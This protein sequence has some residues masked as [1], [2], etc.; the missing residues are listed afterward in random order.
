MLVSFPFLRNADP[1]ETDTIDDG[2]FN[3]GEK[4]GKGAFPVS[5]Q[6]GWHGGVHLVAPGA[7]NDPEPVRAIADGE[8]VFA[9]HSDPMPLNSGSAEVQAAHPLLYYTGWT[10]NGVMLIKHQTEIG[11]GVGVTFYSIYQHLHT[12]ANKPGTET[13]LKKGDKVYRKDPI[14][15]AGAV[16]GKPNRIHFEIVADQRNVEALMGRSAGPLTAPQ[17][18]RTSVWGDMHIVL[19]ANTV[20][21]THDPR[22]ESKAYVVRTSHLGSGGI[23]DSLNSVAQRFHTTPERIRRLNGTAAQ[24]AN[25]WSTVAA[26][27]TVAQRT[28]RVPAQYGAAA[29]A[30]PADLSLE[31]WRHWHATRS[32]RTPADLIISLSEVRGTILLTTRDREGAVIGRCTEPEGGYNLYKT[33]LKHYPG[34]PSAGYEM[35]RFGRILGPDAPGATDMQGGRLPHVRKI[36]TPGGVQAFVDLNPAGVKVYSDADFPDW[37][38]WTFIDDDTDGN[39]RCDSKQLL[40]L[41]EPMAPTPNPAPSLPGVLGEA[42]HT[43]AKVLDTALHYKDR[44]ARAYAKIHNASMRK[45]LSYCVAKLPT[46]WSRDDFDQRW[47]WIKGDDPNDLPANVLLSLCLS[48]EAYDKLKRHHGALAF[49]ED[50]VKGGLALGKVH[51]HFHPLR[52]IEVF[53]RCGWLSPAELRQMVPARALRGAGAGIPAQIVYERVHLDAGRLVLA[54][55]ADLNRVLSKYGINTPARLAAFFGNAV[56][57]TAW[58]RLTEEVQATNRWYAPWIGRGFLQLTHPSNYLDYWYWRGRAIDADVE[59]RLRLAQQ[60]ANAQR[61]NQPLQEMETQLPRKMVDWR[62]NIADTPYDATD[63]A[64]YYWAMNTANREADVASRNV[65]HPFTIHTS[66]QQWPGQRFTFYEHVS[67]RRVSCLINLPGH[68]NRINPQLNGLV[69]RYH[70]HAYAQVLLLDQSIFPDTNG[71]MQFLPANYHVKSE[72]PR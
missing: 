3:L 20:L 22:T 69:D 50:A 49:W 42:V 28:I 27:T 35:L 39:S 11:E 6:F 10:S 58:L 32:G 4:S 60:Q 29:N 44:L 71:V 40:D 53:K 36:V 62:V 38:G 67:F 54:H 45:R 34:C 41:I 61:S 59:R 26:A 17:G 64:G 7:P 65:R 33:A 66:S 21:Y 19:P 1:Q 63:S 23:N 51:Y 37:L 24:A 46:E 43:A 5:H 68:I 48:P 55:S 56:Q 31:D 15:K 9:R 70:A 2:T 57:E 13:P 16:Y 52:F 30:P 47:G 25:W 14:G 12:V 8:V 18:R 72:E